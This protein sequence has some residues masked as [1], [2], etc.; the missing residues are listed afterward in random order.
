MIDPAVLLA[1][2]V[3]QEQIDGL[4]SDLSTFVTAHLTLV[5]AHDE[6]KSRMTE[7]EARIA[8]GAAGLGG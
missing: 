4:V 8:A 2:A 3:M 5:A 7:V 1:L 6:L